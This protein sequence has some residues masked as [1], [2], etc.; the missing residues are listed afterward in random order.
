MLSSR[1]WRPWRQNR[2]GGGQQQHDQQR[3]EHRRR[4]DAEYEPA[5]ESPTD[6]ACD[7]RQDEVALLAQ[8]DEAAVAAVAGE[9]DE[10]GEE[11]T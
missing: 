7:H 5:D 11:A 8:R 1:V 6:R 2:R 9:R 10:L 4:D 3:D